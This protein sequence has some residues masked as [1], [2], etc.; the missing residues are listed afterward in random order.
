M[1]RSSLSYY[2]NPSSSTPVFITNYLHLK[3]DTYEKNN[4]FRNQ[5]ELTT[6]RII[7]II[8]H[9]NYYY[10]LVLNNS[11]IYTAYSESRYPKLPVLIK[12]GVD[13]H[14]DD[15]YYDYLLSP[16]SKCSRFTLQTS[17]GGPEINSF[18]F[19]RGNSKLHIPPH[20]ELIFPNYYEKKNLKYTTK[21]PYSTSKGKWMLDFHNRYVIS[22]AKNFIFVDSENREGKELLCFRK[23]ASNEINCDALHDIQPIV[24][25]GVALGLYLSKM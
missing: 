11:V 24:V 7:R 19:S 13:F 21:M 2:K 16:N 23:V 9:G 15:D 5:P 25:F 4:S 22:S 17:H 12:P 18:S 20:C 3:N 6:Y 14:F 8:Q 10:Q 1:F